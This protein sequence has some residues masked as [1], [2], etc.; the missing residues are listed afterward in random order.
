MPHTI[1]EKAFIPAIRTVLDRVLHH[2]NTNHVLRSIP[3]SNNTVKRRIDEMGQCIEKQLIEMMR[4]NMFSIQV[5]ESTL[6]GNKCLLLVCVR[7][8]VCDT[9]Y[10]ELAM[11]GIMET[12]ST[13][14]LVFNK[15]KKLFRF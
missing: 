13:G 9:T 3:L 14:Q 7:V 2:K 15:I 6:P 4:Y 1:G 11:S 8:I 12:H 10:E 5:D